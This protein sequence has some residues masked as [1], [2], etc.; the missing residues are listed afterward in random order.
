M[1]WEEGWETAGRGRSHGK[2][3]QWDSKDGLILA[4]VHLLLSQSLMGLPKSLKLPCW[5]RCGPGLLIIVRA[6]PQSVSGVMTPANHSNTPLSG[7]VDQRIK[8]SPLRFDKG[9]SKE[10][11]GDLTHIMNVWR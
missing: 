11:E 1:N 3:L 5:Y 8:T 9:E 6:T 7:K 10:G 2:E 4:V